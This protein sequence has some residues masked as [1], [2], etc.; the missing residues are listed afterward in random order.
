MSSVSNVAASPTLDRP[1]ASRKPVADGSATASG[2]GS[3]TDAPATVKAAGTQNSADDAS[4]PKASAVKSL[5]YGALGLENPEET[6]P[7]HSDY[8]TAGRFLAAAA[9]VGAVVSLLI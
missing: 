9:T 2:D 3:K 6:P 5:T 8:Y 7:P 1:V 4:K